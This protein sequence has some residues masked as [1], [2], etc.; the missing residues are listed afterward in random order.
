MRIVVWLVLLGVF[1]GETAD[2]LK[3]GMHETEINTTQILSLFKLWS[4]GYT[5]RT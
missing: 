2:V 1:D 4:T 3:M 5:S